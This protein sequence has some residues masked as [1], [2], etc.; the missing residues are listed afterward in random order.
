[1]VYRYRDT[2]RRSGDTNQRRNVE[3]GPSLQGGNGDGAGLVRF[4]KHHRPCGQPAVVGGIEFLRPLPAQ[5]GHFNRINAMPSD[6]P[7]LSTGLATYPVPPQ[8]GQSIGST[9]PPKLPLSFSPN[10][11]GRAKK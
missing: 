3:P 4:R 7:L 6:P 2:S 10:L 5:A 1:M 11:V 9:Y 8:R